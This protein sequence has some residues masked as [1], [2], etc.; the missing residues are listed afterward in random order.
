MPS[1]WTVNLVLTDSAPANIVLIPAASP[2]LVL[3]YRL[4]H[5]SLH[6]AAS[7]SPC[8]LAP[9]DVDQQAG[10]ATAC[11]SHSLWVPWLQARLTEAGVA[12]A[13]AE[14]IVAGDPGAEGRAGEAGEAAMTPGECC[15]PGFVQPSRVSGENMDGRMAGPQV[16]PIELLW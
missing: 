5:F 3:E 4:A 14:R 13:G 11:C 2:L 16:D 9:S 7:S 10:A 8:L 12:G 1:R 6:K 15:I